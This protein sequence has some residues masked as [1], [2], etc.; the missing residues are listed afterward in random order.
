MNRVWDTSRYPP[1]PLVT[2]RQVNVIRDHEVKK[3]IL[4]ILGLGGVI[5]VF[6]SYLRQE[7]EKMTIEHFLNDPKFENRKNIE[8]SVKVEFSGI[9]NG[10]T[11]TFSKISI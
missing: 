9:Q 11:Q 8:I 3:V 7:R 5:L 6:R 4:E 10:K 1:E 2:S